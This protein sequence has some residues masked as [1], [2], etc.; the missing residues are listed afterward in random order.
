MS[1]RLA[2]KA[3]LVTGA[4]GGI[5]A[6]VAKLFRDQGAQVMT[7]DIAAHHGDSL[8]CDVSQR[9]Q[10]DAAIDAVVARLGRLDIVVHAA[11]LLGGTGNF[12]D[13]SPHDWQ[14]YMDVNLGGTFHV[15]QAAAKIM[16]RSGGGSIVAVGSV[17]SLAAEP[18]AAAYV[19]SKH[20]VLG[21]VRSM[22]VDL[23]AASIRVNMV[24]PGPITVTRNADLFNSP[25]LRAMFSHAVPM[26][27]PGTPVDVAHATLF[28]AEDTS[29]YVTGSVITVDGGTL[30][31]IMRAD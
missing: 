27:R 29:A 17:N 7:A 25:K 2:G 5:G 21:L 23:A 1:Q 4:A 19:A 30:A 3:A 10:V 20:G 28:L 31:Q 26:R 13:V 8:L 9:A 11:A 16:A 18:V 15:C 22:A 14:R 12:L 6:A 24:A